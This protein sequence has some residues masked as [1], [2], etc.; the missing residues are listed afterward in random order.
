MRVL[1]DTCVPRPLRKLLPGH[2][3]STAQ[4]MGWD[5]LENGELIRAAET[6]FE[7]LITADQHMKR[8]QVLTGRNLTI[9]VLP[10]NHLPTVLRLA[11]R[12]QPALEDVRP[13]RFVEIPLD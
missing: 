1:L 9:V 10:T 6:R 8:Q 5:T 11:T 2:E 3:V 4:E 7:V 13:G 12:V